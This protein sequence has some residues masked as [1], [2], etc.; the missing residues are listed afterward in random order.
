LVADVAE[1]RER[2]EREHGTSEPWNV[3]Y[4][5]GGLLDLEFISQY[6]QLRHAAD[7]PEALDTN[8][9]AAF[10]RLEQIGA[11]SAEVAEE[12]IAA[13]LL[14]RN[15]QGLSQLSSE[16]PIDEE[17]TPEGLREALARAGGAADFGALKRDLVAAQARTLDH[18]RRLIEAPARARLVTQA[19]DNRP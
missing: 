8:T 14:M 12:L 2:V 9:S 5:R 1:M 19:Q 10:R 6:L 13:T 3:K 15:L 7:R 18:Y 11:L 17:R 16:G 4:A